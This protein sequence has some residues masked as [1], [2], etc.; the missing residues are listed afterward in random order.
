M[1]KHKHALCPLTCPSGTY[2]YVVNE[3]CG[4]ISHVCD[5]SSLLTKGGNP[6]EATG[7][8]QGGCSILSGAAHWIRLCARGGPWSEL[9][10]LSSGYGANRRTALKWNTRGGRGGKP[11]EN[12]TEEEGSNKFDLHVFF[13]FFFF[14]FLFSSN[15]MLY[16]I[17]LRYQNGGKKGYISKKEEIKRNVYRKDNECWQE[18]F[19][20]IEI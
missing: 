2:V 7:I 18:S 13:F 12:G 11:A 4:F 9:Q 6:I 10:H 3:V 8:I 16:I 19:G 1:R 15:K 20:Y 5:K 17:F 14:F